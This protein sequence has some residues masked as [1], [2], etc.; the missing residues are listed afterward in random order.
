MHTM[1]WVLLIYILIAIT[2]LIVFFVIIRNQKDNKEKSLSDDQLPEN[3][4]VFSETG[5]R[6]NVAH[7]GRDAEDSTGAEN[8]YV[9]GDSYVDEDSYIADE[10]TDE[11]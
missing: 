6:E 8:T 11:M 4:Q 9:A 1:L 2:L 5:S 10:S 3:E 7:M